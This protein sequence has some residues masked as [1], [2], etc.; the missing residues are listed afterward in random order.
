M[1]ERR[2][3]RSTPKSE[4]KR[5]RDW[6][7]GGQREMTDGLD[8]QISLTWRGSRDNLRAWQKF[9]APAVWEKEENT[10]DEKIGDLGTWKGVSCAEK[11]LW[12]V[13]TRR[14]NDSSQTQLGDR[15]PTRGLANFL[16][17]DTTGTACLGLVMGRLGGW[18]G[19]KV[20]AINEYV[21]LSRLATD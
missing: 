6:V 5:A 20:R 19:C 17:R 8:A 16:A 2:R 18:F 12:F 3:V 4:P 7:S 9:A 1:R 11:L 15:A 14:E 10:G 21:V 13:A